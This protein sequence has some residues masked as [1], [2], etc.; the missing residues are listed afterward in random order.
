MA[1]TAFVQNDT[2]T[3]TSLQHRIIYNTET[4]A[5]S[6]DADGNKAGGIAAVHFAT[7]TGAPNLSAADFEIF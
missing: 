6:Y 3:A 7:L 1:G 4:G 5:L 2:G